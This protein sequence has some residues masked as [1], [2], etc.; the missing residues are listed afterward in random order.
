[1]F[2]K[3]LKIYI[4]ACLLVGL[5]FPAL[6]PA[7]AGSL[8]V[9]AVEISDIKDNT[10]QIT[11]MTTI[12]T[13]GLI[14]Y[15]LNPGKL[16]QTG[17]YAALS[18]QHETTL[19]NLTAKKRYYYTITSYDQWGQMQETF[20][21]SFTTDGMLDTI[22]PR[23][24]DVKILQTTPNA[25]VFSW[26]L[27]EK[28]GIAI[29]YAKIEAGVA[30]DKLKY[31]S[32]GSANGISGT[33][34]IYNLT[35]NSSY[36]LKLV[37][38]DSGKNQTEYWARF[39]TGSGDKKFKTAVKVSN[40]QPLSPDST[41]ITTEQAT[42]SWQTNW[43][44]TSKI[45][46]GTK[47]RSYN[48]SVELNKDVLASDHRVTLTGLKANT[49]YYYKI[50]AYNSFY[51]GTFT[52]EEYSFRTA[53]K[54]T[55]QIQTAIPAQAFNTDTDNDGLS[56]GYEISIGTDVYNYDTDG[57]GMLDGT[58][59][60]M[61]YDPKVKGGLLD[62]LYYSKPR[63]TATLEKQKADEL[64]VIIKN[65]SGRINFKAN[66]WLTISNSYIYGDYP[67]EAILR[68]IQIGG[69]TVHSTKPWGVWKNSETYIKY[70]KV[71]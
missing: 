12:P 20:V 23:F 24:S 53:S 47:S 22:A 7:Q 69:Y 8:D 35:P 57:D 36:W 15:G 62:P 51:G 32:G 65:N 71:K 4:L 18:M 25:L 61:G 55:Y 19:Y 5:A 14:Y 49:T 59:V 10:A 54:V 43:I 3:A 45:S 6:Q 33:K 1:M 40:V 26:R 67:V 50:A 42:I 17:G 11:W 56:D 21:R 37:A 28:A 16:D 58:E 38:K 46:Y 48:K 60:K 41:R 31:V 30:D 27:S 9:S 52:S 39:Y 13:K 66:D 68:A 34:F 29:S 2:Q 63:L 44:A 70:M 64:R